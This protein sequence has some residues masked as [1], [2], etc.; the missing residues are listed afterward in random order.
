MKN[1][2]KRARAEASTINTKRTL[3]IVFTLTWTFMKNRA[4]RARAEALTIN[5]KT[6][7]KNR[8]Y[9]NLAIHEE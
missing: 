8:L 1:S 3:K 7:F 6:T 2:A 4:N 9:T 5:T